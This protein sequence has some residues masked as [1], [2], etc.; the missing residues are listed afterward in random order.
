VL[1]PIDRWQVLFGKNLAAFPAAAASSFVLVS[2]LGVFL[3]LS[4]L[5]VLASLLQLIVGLCLTM[6]AGNTMS[7]LVPYRIQ[8]GSMKPTKMPGP[9]MLLM[10]V[11]QL[12]L[13][14]ALTPAYL[15]PL[16]GYLSARSG[17]PDAAVVNVALSLVL[18]AGMVLIYWWSLGP[19]GRLLRKREMTILATV[20]V[21][22]E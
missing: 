12:S 22:V 17:G 21:E 8:P 11:S 16:A 7:I 13:P 10:I 2:A 6:V 4:P 5:V 9:A 14:I 19:A 15:P 18:A 3:H 1:A 20:S